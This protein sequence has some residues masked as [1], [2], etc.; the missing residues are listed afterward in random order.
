MTESSAP[1]PEVLARY[2]NGPSIL[3]AALVDIRRATLLPPP[4]LTLSQRADHYRSR[5]TWTTSAVA[6]RVLFGSYDHE[7]SAKLM[8][9]LDA[10]NDRHGRGTLVPAADG[11]KKEWSTKF[12]MRSPRYTTNWDELPTVR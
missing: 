8:A 3:R 5:F 4:R 1:S 11:F 6:Q 9:A 2:E 12:E 7:R 10:V